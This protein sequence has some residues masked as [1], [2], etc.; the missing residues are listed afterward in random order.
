[1]YYLGLL[2]GVILSMALALP[3]LAA[4]PAPDATAEPADPAAKQ[5]VM[6]SG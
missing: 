6:A 1:M 5:P 3:V 4:E 2:F